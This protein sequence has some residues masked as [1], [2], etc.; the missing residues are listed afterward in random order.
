MEQRFFDSLASSHS[1]SPETA[2]QIYLEICKEIAV[3]LAAN[4]RQSCPYFVIKP[5]SRAGRQ[6]NMADGSVK[7]V[8]DRFFGKVIL[9]RTAID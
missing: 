2:K 9:K 6:K 7:A 8:E 3:K 4:Q 1:I 5:I